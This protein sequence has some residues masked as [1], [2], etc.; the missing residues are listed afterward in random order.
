MLFRSR[1]AP[2][3]MVDAPGGWGHNRAVEA[4]HHF[5]QPVGRFERYDSLV[6][7]HLTWMVEM[8]WLERFGYVALWFAILAICIPTS[9]REW[10]AVVLAVW[11]AFGAAGMFTTML[12]RSMLWVIPGS[13][14]FG[15]SGARV[16]LHDW[17]SR[18][19]CIGLIAGGS[20]A[21]LSAVFFCGSIWMPSKPSIN[22]RLGWVHCVGQ[23]RK[24]NGIAETIWIA[25]PDPAVLGGA[26]G[27]RVREWLSQNGSSAGAVFIDW[28]LGE[29]TP[30]PSD[31]V[32]L[33]GEGVA[34]F[35]SATSRAR[36]WVFLNPE[37]PPET[38]NETLTHSPQ[39]YILWGELN[40]SRAR[41]FWS[42]FAQKFNQVT[43]EDVKSAGEY[44]PN[45]FESLPK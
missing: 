17:P 20:L 18:G 14:L 42:A 10:Y 15:L 28:C 6:S 45:W 40:P 13:L 36:R 29:L 37:L 35:A 22:L 3:M 43:F 12:N 33:S 7:S 2:A 8:S 25:A 16:V 39:T 31:T 26:Y 21:T 34:R 23:A 32:V 30:G 11:L 19:R 27:Q 41:Y 44:L 1:T 38:L 5:Y 9:K 4:F 24:S